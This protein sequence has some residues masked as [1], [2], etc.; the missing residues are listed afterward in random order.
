MVNVRTV[1]A[2]TQC[3]VE[4]GTCLSFNTDVFY[5]EKKITETSIRRCCKVNAIPA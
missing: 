4:E 2:V 1:A 3:E 5:C